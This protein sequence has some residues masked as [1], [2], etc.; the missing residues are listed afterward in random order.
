MGYVQDYTRKQVGVI[1]FLISTT[2][3]LFIPSITLKL[4]QTAEDLKSAPSGNT[5]SAS[6][7]V[8][9]APLKQSLSHENKELLELGLVADPPVWDATTS[10]PTD[11]ENLELKDLYF[12]GMGKLGSSMESVRGRWSFF[13]FWVSIATFVMLLGILGNIVLNKGQVRFDMVNTAALLSVGVHALLLWTVTVFDQFL[14]KP[15]EVVTAQPTGVG[16][17]AETETVV[18]KYA[19]GVDAGIIFVFLWLYSLYYLYWG[20][21]VPKTLIGMK[22]A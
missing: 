20:Q 13:L 22:S 10:A 9:F 3:V 11:E 4:T 14:E 16:G 7:T 6:L 1:L 8:R 15:R 21:V 18:N 12:R 5:K 19:F 17:D 2:C